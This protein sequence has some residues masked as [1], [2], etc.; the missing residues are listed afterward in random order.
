M[1]TNIWPTLPRSQKARESTRATQSGQPPR[2]DLEDPHLFFLQ[3]TIYLGK[4]DYIDHISK[5]QPVGKLI[6]E[7]C[8]A[9]FPLSHQITAHFVFL[10]IGRGGGG[11][12]DVPL[13]YVSCG[14]VSIEGA[15][16]KWGPKQPPLSSPPSSWVPCSSLDQEASGLSPKSSCP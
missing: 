1:E 16:L 8:N 9:V 14:A 6:G 7:S 4:R 10:K 12:P 13:E 15:W 3:V 5:V 11:N 2:V